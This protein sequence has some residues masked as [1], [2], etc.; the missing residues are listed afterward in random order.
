M[1]LLTIIFIVLFSIGLGVYLARRD[2]CHTKSDTKHKPDKREENKRDGLRQIL[3]ALEQSQSG[4]VTNND[5]EVLLGV[6][7][8][9]A[10]RYLS[11]LEQ[12]GEVRQVG[13]TGKGV[14]YIKI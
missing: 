2:E 8:A 10:T 1:N 14:Y 5:V 4:R 3:E 13:S 11:E 7:D 6:S 9:T 12:D